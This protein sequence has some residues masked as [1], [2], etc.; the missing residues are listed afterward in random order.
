[1]IVDLLYGR[2]RLPVQLGDDLDVTVVAKPPMPQLADPAAAVRRALE[3]P[4]GSPPLAAI[5]AGRRSACILVCDV[6][7]PV[8]NGLLLRPLV[9]TL[10][11]AGIDA[12]HVTL[13]VATGLHRP[14]EGAELAALIDDAWVQARV[15]VAN[16]DARDDAAHVDLGA[17]PVRGVPAKLDRRFVEADMRIVTGLVEPHFMAGYSGGRKVVAPGVAHA[18]TIRTFHNASFMA[19]PNAAPCRLAGNP[20]H[21]EQLA[22]LELVGETFAVNTVIDEHRRLSFVNF[23]ETVAS[24]LEAVAF[25][26]NYLTVQCR[27]GSPRW[28]P[29]PPAIRWIAPTTRR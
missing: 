29:P 20:L 5:A 9:E 13:L 3:H 12:G 25:A 18:D 26:E 2:D 24:H 8:P 14:N 19:H 1:M 11:S 23:G 16:H 4:V 28:S 17:T 6:T 22:I 7:R 15:N 27:V 10:L 21:E